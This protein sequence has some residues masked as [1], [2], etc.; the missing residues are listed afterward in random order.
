MDCFQL[1]Y[2]L[3]SVKMDH[4][5]SLCLLLDN[6]TSQYMSDFYD[7]STAKPVAREVAYFGFYIRHLSVCPFHHYERDISEIL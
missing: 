6:V 2:M 7:S 3:V 5:P 4:F 1:L